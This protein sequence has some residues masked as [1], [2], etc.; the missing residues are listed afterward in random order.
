[1]QNVGWLL[2]YGQ[3]GKRP[4]IFT[5]CTR[6]G[7]VGSRGIVY[8]AFWPWSCPSPSERHRSDKNTMFTLAVR[9]STRIHQNDLHDAYDSRT[10]L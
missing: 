5:I 8:S 9:L 6:D 10:L 7:I 2:E 4:T 1:M 3:I